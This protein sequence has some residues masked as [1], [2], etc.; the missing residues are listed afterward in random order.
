[1][2]QTITAVRD[3]VDRDNFRVQAMPLVGAVRQFA[4]LDPVGLQQENQPVECGLAITL[5]GSW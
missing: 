3:V 5:P 1:M 4:D 2:V